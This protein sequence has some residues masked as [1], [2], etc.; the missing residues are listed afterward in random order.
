VFIHHTYSL[1][2]AS[3]AKPDGIGS[4]LKVDHL[5]ANLA[6]ISESESTVRPHSPNASNEPKLPP[7]AKDETEDGVFSMSLDTYLRSF[8]NQLVANANNTP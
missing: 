5:Q 4:A 7:P 6:D 8:A 1:S 2:S 3:L